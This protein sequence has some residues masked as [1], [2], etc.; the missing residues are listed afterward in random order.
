M[1]NS[2]DP[3]NSNQGA[4]AL[5]EVLLERLED[6]H[7]AAEPSLWP[8]APGWWVV[9]GIVMALALYGLFHLVRR[10]R[11]YLRRRRLLR[12]LE[13]LERAF[14]PVARPA[15]YLS[16]LNRLFRGIAVRAF[17]DTHCARLEGEEWVRFLCQRLPGMAEP[18][19]L[20]ALV[21]GPYQANPEFDADGLRACAR[22]WVMEHG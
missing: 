10:L 17:P 9:A 20:R 16:A 13:S 14:D 3:Q 19:P 18:G 2:V 1:Q 5:S 12:Q 6:I 15:D 11:V 21:H 22:H 4:N 8:P 7:A